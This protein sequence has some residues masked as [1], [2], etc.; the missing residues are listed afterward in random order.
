MRVR[1]NAF[2]SGRRPAYECGVP[3]VSVGNIG[4]GG[5]GKTPVAEWLLRWAAQ[6][7]LHAVVLTRGYK[8]K[9]PC[10]PYQVMPDSPPQE[11]GDEPLMLAR[12][13]PQASIV[14]DPIRTRAAE[15]AMNN[16]SPDLFV[17]DD[18]FQHLAVRR[19]V[20]LVLLKQDDLGAEWG[21]VIPSGSWREGAEALSR[22]DAF[23]IKASADEFSRMRGSLGQRL[24]QYDVPVFGFSLRPCGLRLVAQAGGH[25]EPDTASDLDG[26]PY[27]LFSGVGEPA[28]VAR[29]AELFFGYAPAVHHAF[30]DHH[31]YTDA[32]IRRM[33]TEGMPLVCTPKDAVKLAGRYDVPVWTF[34][35]E[36]VFH[37]VWSR[38]GG[39]RNDGYGAGGASGEGIAIAES[40]DISESGSRKTYPED[41]HD[42]QHTVADAA[43]H[44]DCSVFAKWW[45]SRWEAIAGQGRR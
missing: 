36:T 21:R 16:L 17:L 8:A 7:G 3:C 1:R 33:A 26:Q 22:A 4:W 29:T 15:W 14:V 10:L 30:A 12:N 6:N 31:S 25:V 2:E 38:D 20:D 39:Q 45:Q 9:P 43:M 27:V 34:A 19:D 18:G 35:L 28:Q 40:F 13:C 23:C 44:S 24:G 37:S 32:D 41:L 42:G 5:S 11:A